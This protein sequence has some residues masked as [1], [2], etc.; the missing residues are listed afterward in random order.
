MRPLRVWMA[1]CLFVV[2]RAGVATA[3]ETVPSYVNEI[4]QFLVKY[5]IECHNPRKA[6]ARY[7]VETYAAL[8]QGGKKGPM[9]VPGQPERSR[10]I[11][12]M[13]GKGKP[14]PPRKSPQPGAE[15]IAKVRAWIKAGA[16]DDSPAHKSKEHQ[17]TRETPHA[18]GLGAWLLLRPPAPARPGRTMWIGD[19]SWLQRTQKRAAPMNKEKN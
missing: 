15:E 6:K 2:G 12:T 8:L 4:K 17:A 13:E 11:V 19:A 16:K 7:D 5:C 3:A 14:M 9:V 10:L 1:V 18:D